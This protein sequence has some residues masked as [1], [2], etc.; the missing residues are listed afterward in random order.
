MTSIPTN[1]CLTQPTSKKL[2]QDRH[3]QGDP[4]PDHMQRVRDLEH[5]ILSGISPS[6]SSLE[7]PENPEEEEVERL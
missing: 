2:L 6:N 5:S 3:K 1:Q 4:Q 7:D